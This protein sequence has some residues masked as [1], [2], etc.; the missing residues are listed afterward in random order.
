MLSTSLQ[1]SKGTCPFLGEE[2]CICVN[3]S[4]VVQEAAKRQADMCLNKRTL[5]GFSGRAHRLLFLGPVTG[6]NPL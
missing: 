5:E 4:E 6:I 1:Q 2:F 3:H